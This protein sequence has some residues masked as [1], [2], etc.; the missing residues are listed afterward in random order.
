MAAKTHLTDTP[1]PAPPRE[2]SRST[3]VA[4]PATIKH[5]GSQWLTACYRLKVTH[6]GLLVLWGPLYPGRTH[7]GKEEEEKETLVNSLSLPP[8]YRLRVR[9]YT[10]ISCG[11]AGFW[12]P[13]SLCL[14]LLI[15]SE[16]SRTSEKMANI[17][18]DGSINDLRS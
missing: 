17:L 5:L 18:I 11:S 15:D 13:P 2:S 12:P 14:I 4:S 7:G 6:T 1:L 8:H 16:S 3:G 10:R 9:L